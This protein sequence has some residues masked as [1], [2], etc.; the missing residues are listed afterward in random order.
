MSAGMKGL[1]PEE[2]RIKRQLTEAV[3]EFAAE[4]IEAERGNKNA[5]RARQLHAKGRFLNVVCE[6]A[7]PTSTAD[8]IA[9]LEAEVVRLNDGLSEVV[10]WFGEAPHTFPDW[11]TTAEALADMAQNVL[12]GHPALST[13]E[14]RTALA[15]GE[16]S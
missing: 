5:R 15:A 16:G 8:R 10:C 7:A 6:V 3:R 1:E 12:D 14:S 11:K 2:C 9:T 13:P 4:I